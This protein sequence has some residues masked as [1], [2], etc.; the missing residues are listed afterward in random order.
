[1]FVILLE[2]QSKVQWK[3]IKSRLKTRLCS[4]SCPDFLYSACE[5]TLP[6]RTL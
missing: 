5:V 6:Y 1:M 3:W 4:R 2:S